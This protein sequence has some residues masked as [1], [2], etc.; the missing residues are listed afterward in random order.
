[1]RMQIK[2]LKDL[3]YIEFFN[4][5]TSNYFMLLAMNVH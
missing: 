4:F 1:M 3:K 2:L 5:L